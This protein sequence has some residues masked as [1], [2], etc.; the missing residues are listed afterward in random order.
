MVLLLRFG[1]W[2]SELK[3]NSHTGVTWPTWPDD[4]VFVP[5]SNQEMRNVH[6]VAEFNNN[7]LWVK[8]WHVNW[9]CPTVF[10]KPNTTLLV[11]KI[12]SKK[13]SLSPSIQQLHYGVLKFVAAV[14]MCHTFCDRRNYVGSST[15]AGLLYVSLCSFF[16]NYAVTT[17]RAMVRDKKI[18][19]AF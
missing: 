19:P 4:P 13:F 3:V 1:T 9:C 18:P 10:N 15:I 5:W 12:Q 11:N 2:T 16:P 14:L 8:R 7:V 6:L 17:C